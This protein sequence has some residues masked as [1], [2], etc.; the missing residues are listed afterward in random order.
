IKNNSEHD[1]VENEKLL[2]EM[3]EIL[4]KAFE[5][6]GIGGKTNKAYGRLIIDENAE[7]RRL[8]QEQQ[9][10]QRRILEEQNRINEE[11]RKIREQEALAERLRNEA[12]LQNRIKKEGIKA[13]LENCSN[14]NDF[15]RNVLNYKINHSFTDDDIKTIKT[16]VE[17]LVKKKPTKFR[18][19]DR[20]KYI[21]FLNENGISTY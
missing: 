14:M 10:E 8:E 7:E 16:C 18:E 19:K 13:L 12:T 21:S 17:R 2:K 20:K 9:D 5:I 11:N 3:K 4:L 1:I 15:K 6:K